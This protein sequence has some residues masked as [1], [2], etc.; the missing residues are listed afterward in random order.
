MVF[1]CS[2]VG[3]LAR[4]DI[5]WF[6]LMAMLMESSMLYSPISNWVGVKGVKGFKPISLCS[7][8]CFYNAEQT[9]G[10]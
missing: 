3:S 5:Y 6:Y 4:V 1:V 10:C 8:E 2:G 9:F 7:S